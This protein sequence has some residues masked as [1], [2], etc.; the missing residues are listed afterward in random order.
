[1]GQVLGNLRQTPTLRCMR[2]VT[3]VQLLAVIGSLGCSAA[4]Q[5]DA[6]PQSSTPQLPPSGDVGVP[7]DGAPAPGSDGSSPVAGGD[8]TTD[9]GNENPGSDASPIAAPSAVPS[10]PG[11]VRTVGCDTAEPGPGSLRRLTTAELQATLESLFDTDEVPGAEVLAAT[12][13]DGYE[14]RADGL[15]VQDLGAQT[16]MDY[17]DELASWAVS[18]RS[19]RITNC[20][21]HQLDCWNRTVEEFGKRV[22]REPLTP[23]QQVRYVGL[24]ESASDFE[25]GLTLV[26]KTMFQSPY[27]LYRRELGAAEVAGGSAQLN[28][29]DL[30]SSLSYLITGTMPDDEL[31]RKADD[32]SISEPEELSSQVERLL[33]SDLAQARITRFMDGWLGLEQVF[34]QVKDEQEFEVSDE[35]R[36]AMWGETT[37]F[38]ESVYN[39]GT[40][41]D[42]LA[43]D[44]SYVNA[45]LGAL[46]E[47]PSVTNPTHERVALAG[48]QRVGG[49][50]GQA[51]FLLGH[52]TTDH[53]S[54]TERGVAVRERLLCLE[55]PPPPPNVNT[56]LPDA[57]SAQTTRELFEQHQADPSCAGCHALIDP[58]GYGFENYDGFG[59]YRDTENGQSVDA[60]GT[61]VGLSGG[62]VPFNGLAELTAVL[63]DSDQVRNC[64][65]KNL[66]EYAFGQPEWEAD[67]CTSREV[68][69]LAIDGGDTLKSYLR[70]LTQV[71]HFSS[72]RSQ[73]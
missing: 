47:M 45:D 58:I 62:A 40:F 6:P 69:R 49:L 24:F 37:H 10:L 67:A 30:A 17:A 44:Y 43:A 71:P 33:D 60:S 57:A 70:A 5:G 55:L 63:A 64:M 31:F 25:T 42:L 38:I 3:T 14:T 48:T 11:D 36:L 22:F 9:P 52:S 54:P 26:V 50:L 16:L 65:A 18:S 59:R 39:S 23:T 35:L 66:A 68:A 28:P 15:L 41:T 2:V 34:S 51:T 72:R 21:N 46:Y 73:Q 7:T 8:P 12:V 20:E 32:G 19:W 56:N 27:F 4:D 61:L 29:Y 1:M 13:V 53:S